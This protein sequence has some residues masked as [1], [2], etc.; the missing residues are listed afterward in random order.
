MAAASSPVFPALPASPS[1]AR[2]RYDAL[3]R[4][5][6]FASRLAAFSLSTL[7][8]LP[9]CAAPAA[10]A[11]QP[12]APSAPSLRLYVF[13]C[14]TLDV[15]DVGRY[16]LR[17][18]EVSSD[19]LSVGCYLIAHPRGT[20]LWETGAVPDGLVEPGGSPRR[21]HLVLPNAQ[22][23]WVAL[24]RPL[25]AQLA[26]AGYRPADITFLALSHYH[27]DHTANSN[28]YAGARWLVRR[29]ERDAM[30]ADTPPDLAAPK[31]YSALRTARTTIISTPDYDVFGDGRVVIKFAPGHTPG[32]QVLS[33]KLPR[34]GGV[35]LS[36][37]LYHY[38]EERTLGRIPT[39]DMDE[40]QTA[41]SRAAL[42]RFLTASK[43]Q[44]WI[45]HDAAGFA[46][47]RKAPAYYD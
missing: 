15:A 45:Q 5:R 7:A 28:D 19:T 46:R 47:L 10:D 43:A 32:H 44:L 40:Q 11:A 23:R 9:G 31:T 21:Y 30:F 4:G 2:P 35:V 8:A 42:E 16:R 36:G 17:R 24:A 3:M 26:D 22:E 18:D 41:A 12:G 27:Y 6:S 33:V 13:D 38:P 14:G 29:V 39:F 37:D 20:L 25:K 1:P 34:T